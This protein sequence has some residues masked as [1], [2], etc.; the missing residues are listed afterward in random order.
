MRYA[1]SKKLSCQLVSINLEDLTYHQLVQK[2]QTQDNQ[3][4]AAIV[5]TCK[6]TQR[7]QLP[8]KPSQQYIFT[9]SQAIIPVT[10]FK[11][12]TPN[13]NTIN[14]R[15]SK[16]FTKEKEHCQMES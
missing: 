1:P 10:T 11:P 4:H 6:I 2:C 15:H 7:S 13:T 9:R 3:L 14:L 5:K 12:A 8:V 16:L